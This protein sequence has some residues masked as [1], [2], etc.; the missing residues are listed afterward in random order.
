[1]SDKPDAGIAMLLAPA[2]KMGKKM[3]MSEMDKKMPDDDDEP[4][5]HEEEDGDVKS[6]HD[7][8]SAAMGAIKDDDVGAFTEALQAFVHALPEP[9]EE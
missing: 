7:A 3:P 9:D 5:E 8:A 4:A 2:K 1:M 6:L